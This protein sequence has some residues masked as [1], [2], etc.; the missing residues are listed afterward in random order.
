VDQEAVRLAGM[1]EKSGIT[2]SRWI[3]G[4][5]EKN[6][7]IDQD[8]NLRGVFFWGHAPNS[9]T[10]GLEMKKAMDKLDLLVVID[11]I[12]RPRR[13]CPM[14]ERRVPAAGCTQFETSGS[15]RVEPLAAVAREGHRAA[16]RIEARPHDHVRVRKKLGFDKELVKNY[17]MCQGQQGMGRAE[18]EDILREINAGNWTIGY[19][20]Q[21]PERLKAT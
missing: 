19:T 16:V 11:P 14:Q 2:V 9:Q 12:R 7:L 4:V 1:M 18:I 6:E 3:D 8:S 15:H 17:K 10:R 20:G 13:R 21:S 5:L